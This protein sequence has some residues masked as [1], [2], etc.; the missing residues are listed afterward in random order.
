MKTLKPTFIFVAL[1]AL[2]T[3]G[4]Y[5]QFYRPGMERV[6]QGPYD[7]LYNR[8]DSTA[9]DTTLQQ[10]TTAYEPSPYPYYG[11]YASPTYDSWYYWGRPRTRWGFDFNGFDPAYYWSYYGYYDYY[12]VP[13]WN[14][15]YDPWYGW[16]YPGW[17]GG[18]SGI[19]PTKRPGGRRDHSSSGG[20]GTYAEPQPAPS[21][22]TYSNPTPSNPPPSSGG[23]SGQQSGGDQK[24]DGKR[25]R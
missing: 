8:N 1:L 10:D 12:G 21:S 24:R 13:W 23:S 7:Q 20:S 22:P 17:N 14:G 3:A 5:T 16:Q 15:Y 19:P 4:C 6:A 9:I 25:G 11:G 2:L 18:G